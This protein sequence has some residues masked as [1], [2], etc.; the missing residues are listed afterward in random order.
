MRAHFIRQAIGF[1]IGGGFLE[2]FGPLARRS[3]S[4]PHASL[5]VLARHAVSSLRQRADFIVRVDDDHDRGIRGDFLL[6]RR[7]RHG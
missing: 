4:V 5:Q 2:E 1:E 7:I 3:R 6:Q